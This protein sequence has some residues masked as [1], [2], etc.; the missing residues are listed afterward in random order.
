MPFLG[1]ARTAQLSNFWNQGPNFYNTEAFSMTM[2]LSTTPQPFQVYTFQNNNTP[3]QASAYLANTNFAWTAGTVDT[4]NRATWNKEKYTVIHTVR[5]SNAQIDENYPSGSSHD[6]TF[7]DLT[8]D[9]NASGSPYTFNNVLGADTNRDMYWSI[10][11]SSG[12]FEGSVY[13]YVPGTSTK[14]NIDTTLSDTWISW[15]ITRDAV[16]NFSNWTG[17]TTYT[18]GMRVVIANAITGAILG[19]ADVGS[20]NVLGTIPDYPSYS[21][22]KS[23]PANSASGEA[24]FRYESLGYMYGNYT[25]T[26]DIG[27]SWV[28]LGSAIDG[29]ASPYVWTGQ[30]IAT[31]INSIP[32]WLFFD[33]R[34]SPVSSGGSGQT[35]VT[36]ATGSLVSQTNSKEWLAGAGSGQ[37]GFSNTIYPGS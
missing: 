5:M 31:T 10:S 25:G 16:A 9:V 8:L 4:T 22:M 13:F 2:S 19:K 21:T 36:T 20:F 14:L 33:G 15:I 35:T 24:T 18:Y 29:M 1:A 28:A 37:M 26:M 23:G 27:A 34:T 17:N 30:Q 11:E 32:A 3:T 7:F 6:R 12:T